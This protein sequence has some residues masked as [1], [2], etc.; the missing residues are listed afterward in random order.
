MICDACLGLDHHR[1][2]GACDCP[3]C[4]RIVGIP[5][6]AAVEFGVHNETPGPITKLSEDEEVDFALE[7]MMLEYTQHVLA[8][9]FPWLQDGPEPEPAEVRARLGQLW[10]EIAKVLEPFDENDVHRIQIV[11]PAQV[12]IMLRLGG[13][14]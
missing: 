7:R 6:G 4:A 5:S 10:D 11:T 1:C 2:S 12:E 14:R 3:V 8:S 9:T 13:R